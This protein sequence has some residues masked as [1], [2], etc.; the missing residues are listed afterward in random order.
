MPVCCAAHMIS[1]MTTMGALVAEHADQQ[2]EPA[3]GRGADMWWAL[4]GALVALAIFLVARDGLVDDAYITLSYARN[5]AEHLHWG[6][7]PAEES[8]T[9]TSPLNVLMLAAA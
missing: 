5:V 7:I 3:R 1:P 9:A 8:N 2:P 4:P 6:M